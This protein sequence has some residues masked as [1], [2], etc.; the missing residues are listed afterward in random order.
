MK[1]LI[2]NSKIFYHKGIL[3]DL[4]LPET[5]HLQFLLNVEAAMFMMDFRVETFFK[6]NSHS[7]TI[8]ILYLA[9]SIISCG[10]F[11]FITDC[12]AA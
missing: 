10:D 11:Y 6:F 8:Y 7:S 2:P 9:K 5:I 12:V 3:T 4:I 1:P